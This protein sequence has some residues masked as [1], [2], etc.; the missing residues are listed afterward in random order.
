MANSILK[1]VHSKYWRSR[2]KQTFST[3]F[4]SKKTKLTRKPY[5]RVF[6]TFMKA[7]VLEKKF[8]FVRKE[9]LYLTEDCSDS[10]P[11]NP[12]HLKL[13]FCFDSVDSA[14]IPIQYNQQNIFRQIFEK[15]SHFL[16]CEILY[17]KKPINWAFFHSQRG[18]K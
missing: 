9:T 10:A 15:K 2:E 16:S 4:T 3:Q 6:L 14:R 13:L 7:R 18:A 5:N 12:G 8:W 17:Y 11:V 1:T